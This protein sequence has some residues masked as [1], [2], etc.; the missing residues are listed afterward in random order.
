MSQDTALQRAAALEAGANAYLAFYSSL[1]PLTL[2]QLETVT[3]SDVRFKDPFNDVHGRDA[4]RKVL[5]HMFETI[6]TPRTTIV[7]WGWAA[8]ERVF[9]LWRFSAKVPVIGDWQVEGMSDL[10]FAADGRVSAHID[11]WDA[12]QSFYARLPVIGSLIGFIRRRASAQ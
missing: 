9:V 5:E 4:Y 2:D 10:H 8:P 1:T 12:S 6:G 7:H 11:H 3:T